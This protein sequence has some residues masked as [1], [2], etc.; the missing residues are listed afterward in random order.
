MDFNLFIDTLLEG[1]PTAIL[2]ALVGIVWQGIYI[3]GRDKARDQ[4]FEQQRQL[5]ELK[6]QLEDR[7][8]KHQKELEDLRFQYEQRRWREELAREI[9]M[10]HVEARV[11]ENSRAWSYTEGFAQHTLDG[12]KLTTA[13]AQEIAAKIKQWRYSKGGL[14]A[15]ETTRDA[16]YALQKAL[17]EYSDKKDDAYRRIRRARLIFRNSLRADMGLGEVAGQSIYEVAEARHKI[18]A[19]L[20]E[21]QAQMG[22]AKD[23]HL[24]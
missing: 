6:F 4:Q 21:L 14:L 2:V 18:R 19:E 24:A 17:W 20:S 22:L 9:T 5:E 12:E 8:F 23:D 10:K 11:D 1:T 3:Y 15:E 7:R 16:A 13:T